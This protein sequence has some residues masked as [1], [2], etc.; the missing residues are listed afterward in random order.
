MVK[1]KNARKGYFGGGWCHFWVCISGVAWSW[2][3]SFL[4]M[5][6]CLPMTKEARDNGLSTWNLK[7]IESNRVFQI[8][9]PSSYFCGGLSILTAG[10]VFDFGLPLEPSGAERDLHGLPWFGEGTSWPCHLSWGPSPWLHVLRGSVLYVIWLLGYLSHPT[11]VRRVLLCLTCFL[12]ALLLSLPELLQGQHGRHLSG[13]DYPFILGNFE[14]A[15][16]LMVFRKFPG[17]SLSQEVDG[18]YREDRG[19]RGFH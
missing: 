14:A 12:G 11:S 4:R 13:L 10:N 5:Q 6:E 2:F 3:Q 15:L 17:L 1:E 8:L 9:N 16:E 7:V 18:M 19:N